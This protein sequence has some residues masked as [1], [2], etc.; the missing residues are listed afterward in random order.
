MKVHRSS[1]QKK[2]SSTVAVRFVPLLCAFAYCLALLA[3][4]PLIAQ[5]PRPTALRATGEAAGVLIGTAV[6]PSHLKEA[7]YADT[8]RSEFSQVEPE[9]AM[10]FGPIHP[11]P[12]SDPNPFDFRAADDLVSFAQQN[13]MKVRGH[14]LLWHQQLSPWLTEGIKAGT[15]DAAALNS[16]LQNH[17]RMV[18]K[19]YSGKV[20]AWDVVNEAFNEDGTMRHTPWYDQ[21]GIG[22][23]D[24]KTAYIEQA[25]RWAH[26]ADPA[27]KLFYNDYDTEQVNAKSDAI[28]QMASDFKSRGVP[29]SGI[30]FQLH[31]NLK[32]NDAQK[33][34]SFAA[35]LKRFSDRGLE[36]HITELDVA[37]DS[38]DPVNLAAQG[39]LYHKIAQICLQTPACKLIQTW[40]FTDKY[41][42]IPEY[43]QHK[44]GWALPFDAEYKKKSAFAGILQA[45]DEK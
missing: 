26:E 45:L 38:P 28:Y 3:L 39:E 2:N 22:V 31:V 18:M 40:G 4:S 34:A 23:A 44:Q 17:I 13:G 35:N 33:L 5:S 12:N 10:K 30:G 36:I 9:N 42:W 15:F 14:T 16:I 20:Y 1:R 32:F 25:F 29:L 43:S 8:L 21:P 24:Q 19:H 41:S 7:D 37:L 27:A 6:D 11:R